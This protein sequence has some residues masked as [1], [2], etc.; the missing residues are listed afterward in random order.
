MSDTQNFAPQFDA[1]AGETESGVLRD[2][3]TIRVAVCYILENIKDN[4]T[5]DIIIEAMTDSEIANYYEVSAAVADLVQDKIITE[6]PD[7]TLCLSSKGARS[8]EFLED[9]LPKTVREK[10]ISAV[11][12]LAAREMYKK[13]TRCTIEK[14]DNGWRVI[15]HVNDDENDFMTLTLYTASKEQAAVI[16]EKFTSDPVKVYNNLIESIFSNES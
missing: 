15:L 12:K 13:Q 14:A 8:V 10:S 16:Q 2:K 7:G 3:A 5:A 9:N 1:I 4:L 11:M 6:Q